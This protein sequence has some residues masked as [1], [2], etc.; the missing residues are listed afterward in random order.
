MEAA[1]PLPFNFETKVEIGMG[2]TEPDP[3]QEIVDLVYG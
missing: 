1:P 2:A 3:H